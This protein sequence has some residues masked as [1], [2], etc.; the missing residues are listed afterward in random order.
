MLKIWGSALLSNTNILCYW[1]YLTEILGIKAK[2]SSGFV[3][4]SWGGKTW[5]SV[6]GISGF[7]IYYENQQNLV[8]YGE[9]NHVTKPLRVWKIYFLF[10]TKDWRLGYLIRHVFAVLF[11]FLCYSWDKASLTCPSGHEFG[12]S[13][14]NLKFWHYM[15]TSFHLAIFFCLKVIIFAI[16]DDYTQDLAHGRLMLYR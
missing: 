16:T 10:S 14:S 2:F 1:V 15:H 4:L 13:T 6:L 9:K 3:L 5:C 11:L 7:W 8:F 12:S